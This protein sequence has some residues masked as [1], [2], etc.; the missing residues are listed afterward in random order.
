MGKPWGPAAILLLAGCASLPAPPAAAPVA[1]ERGPATDVLAGLPPT[2]VADRALFDLESGDPERQARA[3]GLLLA[4]PAWS[5]VDALRRRAVSAPEGSEGRLETLGVL[6]E[7]GEPLE[8]IGI[9]EIVAM[10]VREIDRS[11]APSRRGLLALDRIRA[12]GESAREALRGEAAAD[13][14][15]ADAAARVLSR[16]FGETVERRLRGARQ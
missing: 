2:V 12:L 6:A 4:L 5:C 10:N 16:L 13:G 9:G 8:G 3:R 1:D 15:R 7:R 14:P 11:G